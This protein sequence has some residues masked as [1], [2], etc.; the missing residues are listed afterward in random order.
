MKPQIPL[1]ILPYLPCIAWVQHALQRDVVLLEA[2]EHY[3]KQSYRNRTRILSANGVQALQIPVLH[4]SGK[5]KI[6]EI[7]TDPN[8]NWKRNH[9]Q[10]IESA[11]NKSAFFMYYRHLFEPYFKGDAQ[12]NLW[13]HNLGLLQVI[14]KILKVQ[15]RFEHTRTYEKNPEQV[16]DL[17]AAFHCKNKCPETEL[18]AN[19]KYLQVFAE[20]YPF[21]PNLSVLDLLFNAGPDA[22]RYLRA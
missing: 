9:W 8:E 14:F 16:L 3:I 2:S 19:K 22:G 18:I 11:Y 17:R 4:E 13:Q 1:M 12:V 6:T 5:Q 15:I 21:E 7:E 10:S 20:K